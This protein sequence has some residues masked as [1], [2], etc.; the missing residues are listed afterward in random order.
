MWYNGPDWREQRQTHRYEQTCFIAKVMKYG[1][2]KNS[3]LNKW[4]GF[5]GDP[6]GKKMKPDPYIKPYR[7]KKLHMIQ[8]LKCE[9]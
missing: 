5:T 8:R 1:L 3:L 9:R 2:G 4:C 7:R 6:Y